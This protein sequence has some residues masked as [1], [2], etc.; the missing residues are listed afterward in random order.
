MEGNED[1]LLLVRCTPTEQALLIKLAQ[2]SISTAVQG[3]VLA[4]ESVGELTER[5]KCPAAT[6]ITLRQEGQLRGCVGNLIA[7]D[8]LYRSV[9]HNAIGAALRDSRFPPVAPEELQ[10]IKIHISILS[11][12]KSIHFESVDQMLDQMIPGE[13][14]VV[15]RKSGR[16]ATYLPQVWK[17]FSQKE[18][19][20][21]SLSQK[22]GLKVNAWREHDVEILLYRVFEFGETET[23]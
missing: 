20:L 23:D 17:T 3:R 16:A 10:H 19:F 4:A 6:F 1:N 15:L 21:D 8:P 5:L 2:E 12:L 13:D 14:G 11:A 7:R 9:I 22:A 18:A